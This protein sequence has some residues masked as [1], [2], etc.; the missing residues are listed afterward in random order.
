MK[1][2]SIATLLLLISWGCSSVQ[3]YYTFHE[4][5]E[6]IEQNFN[7]PLFAHAHWGVHIESLTTGRI[8]YERNS[9]RMFMPASN[10]KIP[11]AASALITLG[12]DF[13]YHTNLYY[14]GEIIDSILKGDLIVSGNG[15]P[16]F[17]TRFFDDPRDPFFNFADSIIQLGIK[18]IDG[19]IIG[20][21][22]TFD[23]KGYGYGWSH[24]GLGSWYSA[25]SGALQFN[26]NYIDLK[27][28]PPSNINDSVI[29][30]P[31][32]ESNYFQI[33]NNIT[34]I[35]SGKTR[36]FIER[37]FGSNEISISGNI[38]V[39]ADTLERSYSVSNPT[40]FYTTVL[41]ET[42]LNK[43]IF[44][45]GN[46]IDCDDIE[47]W[48]IDD[49]DNHLIATQVSP[50][51]KELLKVLMK[52]SQNMYAETMVKTMGYEKNGVGSFSEGKKIV[53]GVL[54]D[55]GIEP[56]TYAYMDGSGLSRY[57]FISPAQIVTIL[58]RMKNSEYWNI[59]KET[60]PI[61]GIDGTLRRRMR[62]SKAEGNV[63]AKTGTISNVRGLSGY[64]STL[65][66]EEIVFSF[67][68]NGH[69]LKSKDTEL[70]TDRVLSLIAEYPYITVENSGNE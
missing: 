51:L 11:T 49:R 3:P 55:F 53:E 9:D 22:N 19:D 48:N 13:A 47:D 16:T 18:K 66:G 52:K 65:N 69:L 26:E 7:D 68:V 8:W 36:I 35:D 45:S 63:R 2:F 37:P 23:D 42:L 67:L 58:K 59:W 31:N 33:L 32:V 62:G 27:I 44:V 17:Y 34:V 41:K 54:Q 28:I 56:K 39:G 12:E 25:E 5:Q 46:A 64:L 40:L 10:E 57:D 20:D 29:I 38:L 60:L 70:I 21:D 30:I 6:L 4:T 50:P 61:A 1:Y 14:S 15:D 43:G 24:D